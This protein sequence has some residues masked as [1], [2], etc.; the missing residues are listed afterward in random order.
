[1][2]KNCCYLIAVL[3]LFCSLP[4]LLANNCLKQTY[5][6]EIGVREATGSNDGHRVEAYL[7]AAGLGKGYAW[8]AAFVRWCMD[9]CGIATNINAWSPTAHN[10]RQLVWF[11]QQWHRDPEPG[12]VFTLWYPNLKRI[13]HTG[14]FDGHAGDDMVYT[15]EGNTNPG[16]SR[17]G[18]GVYRRKRRIRAI[19]SIT[20]WH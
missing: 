8:C 3:L 17:E 4:D 14:F 13:G 1:M 10:P 5:S 15:V 19:H 6:A 11:R 18:D 7:A 12:D 2:A 9:R 20:R 16:G